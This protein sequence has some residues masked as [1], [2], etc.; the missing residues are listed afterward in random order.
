MFVFCFVISQ[1]LLI[2]SLAIINLITVEFYQLC[3]GRQNGG[4]Y[5]NYIVQTHRHNAWKCMKIHSP[6]QK[7]MRGVYPEDLKL[8]QLSQ[9][10]SGQLYNLSLWPDRCMRWEEKRNIAEKDGTVFTLW[11][12]WKVYACT[13]ESNSGGLLQTRDIHQCFLNCNSFLYG[14]H[15][16]K[17]FLFSVLSNNRHM[18]T[19]FREF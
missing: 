9:L 14:V 10:L 7:G 11:L 15:P 19:Y 13:Q 8:H 6:R 17:P 5:K 1:I 2:K 18:N 12:C 16:L 3:Y 4:G